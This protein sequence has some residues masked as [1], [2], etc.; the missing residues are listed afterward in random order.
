MFLFL[1]PF[2]LTWPTEGDIKIVISVIS[3]I[4]H[5]R[6]ILLFSTAMLALAQT[7]KVPF[8]QQ[9]LK[10]TEYSPEE[11]Q[12]LVKKFQGLLVTDVVD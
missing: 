4:L 8:S 9:I 1:L 3:D 10:V 6:L 12:A 11:N 7:A 2:L 5:M